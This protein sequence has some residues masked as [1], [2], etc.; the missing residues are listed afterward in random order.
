MPTVVRK[1]PGQTD[2]KLIADF[3]KKV[4]N[5]EVILEIKKREF[6]RKPSIV[7]QEKMKERRANRYIKRRPA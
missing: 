3:R 6:Y 1:K 2:D 5:D 7:K 4:L